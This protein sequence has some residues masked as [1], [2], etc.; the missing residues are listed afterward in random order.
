VNKT[1]AIAW[2][3]QEDAQVASYIRKFGTYIQ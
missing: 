3:D 1:Q 2:L